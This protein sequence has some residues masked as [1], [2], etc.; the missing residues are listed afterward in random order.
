MPKSRADVKHIHAMNQTESRTK[1]S[2]HKIVLNTHKEAVALLVVKMEYGGS[3]FRI[4]YTFC[5]ATFSW[6]NMM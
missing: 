2:R 4:W 5:L 1:P 3:M 6:T